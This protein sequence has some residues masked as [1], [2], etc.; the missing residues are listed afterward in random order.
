[1]KREMAV[2]NEQPSK[3]TDRDQGRHAHCHA[4]VAAMIGCDPERSPERSQ[5]HD[6]G[7][8]AHATEGP[9]IDVHDLGHSPHIQRQLRPTQRLASI[10][11]AG[12]IYPG[13][14]ATRPTGVAFHGNRIDERPLLPAVSRGAMPR[15]SLLPNAKLAGALA[16][17]CMPRRL[18]V[19]SAEAPW[20]EARRS[21][22]RGFSAR[23]CAAR[24]FL[25]PP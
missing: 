17:I 19:G 15:G 14:F 2:Q 16:S 7:A 4:S 21:F 8:V 24:L 5:C 6:H 20:N 23:P 9:E 13:R 1:V 22:L 25:L 12:N 3:S 18:F 11:L 10:K